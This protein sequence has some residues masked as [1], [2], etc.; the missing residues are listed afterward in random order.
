MRWA[1]RRHIP[2]VVGLSLIVA[3]I[4]LVTPWW[5]LEGQGTGAPD[6]AV[7][8][9]DS[10]EVRSESGVLV[11]VGVLDFVGLVGLVGGLVL[12]LRSGDDEEQ[13]E[14]AGWLWLGS[15]GFLLVAALAAVITWPAE[16][17]TFWG[18]GEMQRSIFAASAGIGWYLTVAAGATAAVAGMAWVLGH[19]RGVPA[20]EP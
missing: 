5:T 16:G 9:F 17:L 20:R 7:S 15:G 2:I 13:A 10:G 8:P 6:L 18:T 3:A 14:I 1:P 12:G 4:G 11:A 19:Q